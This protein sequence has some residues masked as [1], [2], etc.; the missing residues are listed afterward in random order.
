MEQASKVEEY[1]SVETLLQLVESLVKT[2]MVTGNVLVAVQCC[3]IVDGIRL[4]KGGIL[5][6]IFLFS[7]IK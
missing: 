5:V 7:K 3:R 6:V 1:V 4:A 2:T